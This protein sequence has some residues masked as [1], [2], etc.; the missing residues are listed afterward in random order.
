MT[1]Q[2]FILCRELLKKRIGAY[3]YISLYISEPVWMENLQ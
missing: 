2:R 1:G 3:L